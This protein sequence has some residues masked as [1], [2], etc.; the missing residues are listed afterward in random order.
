MGIACIWSDWFCKQSVCIKFRGE[1]NMNN[2]EIF[3]AI[4]MIIGIIYVIWSN[5]KG[6]DHKFI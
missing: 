2:Y 6:I 4:S 3:I 5:K 1:K